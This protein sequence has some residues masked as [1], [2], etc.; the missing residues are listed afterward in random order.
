VAEEVA[1]S[2]GAM[3]DFIASYGLFGIFVGALVEGDVTL[4]LAG[5]VAHLGLVSPVA[6]VGVGTCGAMLSDI[7]F[8]LAGRYSKPRIERSAMYV[9]ARPILDRLVGRLG[10][11]QVLLA[12]FV[13]GTRVASMLF[14]GMRALP[15][16]RFAILDS[17]ACVLWAGALVGVGFSLSANAEAVIGDVKKTELWLLGAL[18]AGVVIVVVL[19]AT[20]RRLRTA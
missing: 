2:A 13:Y 11:W 12:R 15:W 1:R 17:L 4:I 14:W 19:R 7:G 3:E 18:V 8:Y 10:A 16:H 5:V 20:G 9:Q 6:A